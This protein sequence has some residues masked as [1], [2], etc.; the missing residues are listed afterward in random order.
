M[1]AAISQNVDSAALDVAIPVSL[2]TTHLANGINISGG[3]TGAMPQYAVSADGRFVLN[4]AEP[5]TVAT[6]MTVVLNWS[7]AVSIK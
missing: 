4:V 1:A 3:A 5:G 2:F 7:A 6:P